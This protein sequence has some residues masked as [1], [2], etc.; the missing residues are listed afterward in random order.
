LR[1]QEVECSA[2]FFEEAGQR[3]DLEVASGLR[4]LPFGRDGNL[5]D[6]IAFGGEE[7][8]V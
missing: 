8:A 4:P 5:L 6:R 1:L 3:A 7:T 2:V